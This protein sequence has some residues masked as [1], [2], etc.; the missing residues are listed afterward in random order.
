L[1]EAAGSFGRGRGL[2]PRTG[3][4]ENAV[5]ERRGRLLSRGLEEARKRYRKRK[6]GREEGTHHGIVGVVS[7]SLRL[8]RHAEDRRCLA[9]LLG[10]SERNSKDWTPLRRRSELGRKAPGDQYLLLGD[11]GEGQRKRL[12][13]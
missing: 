10:M 6:E 9:C 5:G 13:A 8:R 12:S 7:V 2:L 1:G 3:E 11:A 4:V